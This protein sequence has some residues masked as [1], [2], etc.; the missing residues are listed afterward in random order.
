MPMT[1]VVLHKPSVCTL[2]S[3]GIAARMGQPVQVNVNGQG[4]WFPLRAWLLITLPGPHPCRYRLLFLAHGVAVDCRGFHLR[5]P[6]PLRDHIQ[7]HTFRQCMD[8]EAM[9]QPLWTLVGT[10]RDCCVTHDGFH[11]PPGRDTGPRPQLASS[12]ALLCRLCA[13]RRPCTISRVSISDGGTGTALYTPLRRFLRDSNIMVVEIDTAKEEC[14]GFRYPAPGIVQ[15]TAQGPYR[16]VCLRRSVQKGLT[17]GGRKIQASTLGV[18]ELD[19]F[20]HRR[21]R[22]GKRPIERD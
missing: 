19:G 13:S 21:M 8:G 16:P 14:H 18:I 9:S 10:V 17:L 4:A 15:H 7:R 2:I 20:A 6:H 1:E 3:Q 11:L 12:I 5:M 22:P